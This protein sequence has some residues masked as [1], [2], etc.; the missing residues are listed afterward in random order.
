MENLA[1]A[2]VTMT[3]VT[4]STIFAGLLAYFKRAK[5]LPFVTQHSVAI[6]HGWLL[7]SSAGAALGIHAIWDGS[8]HSLT[9]SGLDI[10]AILHGIWTWAEQW[11]VQYLVQR[12]IF[13][14]VAIPGDAPPVA[15]T[16]V[17]AAGNTAQ[18]KTL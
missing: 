10:V 3:Q 2:S 12:G 14:P 17:N 9:I 18:G 15:V 13:G 7:L 4:L 5:W 8:S 16:T 6:N 11:T 1:T